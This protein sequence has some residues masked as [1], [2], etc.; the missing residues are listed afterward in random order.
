MPFVD[1]GQSGEKGTRAR[2][3]T[4]GRLK[5]GVG[6]GLG[7][8]FMG[9]EA[10]FQSVTGYASDLTEAATEEVLELTESVKPLVEDTRFAL[11]TV[12]EFIP[13]ITKAKVSKV[14]LI[15]AKMSGHAE[16]HSGVMKFAEK[17]VTDNAAWSRPELADICKKLK[18]LAQT[19]T[20]F[21][22]KLEGRDSILAKELDIANKELQWYK[23]MECV[24]AGV[25]VLMGALVVGW[26]FFHVPTADEPEEAGHG[27]D[28]APVPD[29]PQIAKMKFAVKEAVAICGGILGWAQRNKGYDMAN[30]AQAKLNNY[31]KQRSCL[32]GAIRDAEVVKEQLMLVRDRIEVQLQDQKQLASAMRELKEEEEEEKEEAPFL[33]LTSRP[34]RESFMFSID[35]KEELTD[36]VKKLD[37]G[38]CQTLIDLFEAEAKQCKEVRALADA[39]AD[40]ATSV[41]GS[42]ACLEEVARHRLKK[43]KK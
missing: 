14:T 43:C 42:I 35:S 11:Q 30:F 2:A 36:F 26:A 18:V 38:E 27:H 12:A 31:V 3:E 34:L 17:A 6:S 25:T 40:S 7:E 37:D 23:N 29:D 21:K 32:P 10:L 33:T 1:E 16:K 13:D 41:M 9:L 19:W 24:C 22:R 4:V 8:K 5:A 15:E 39:W 20:E 28:L